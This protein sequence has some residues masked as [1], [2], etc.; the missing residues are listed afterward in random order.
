MRYRV[1]G[2]TVYA[3]QAAISASQPARWLV[4]WISCLPPK[5]RCLDY[6]C[7]RL[8]YATHL[9]ARAENTTVVDSSAQL[10]RVMTIHG[11][12]C[13]IPEFAKRHHRNMR[14]IA[15]R[16]FDERVFYDLAIC[17]NVLSSIPNLRRR[18]QVC[19]R[20]YEAL[21]PGGAALFVNQHRN[22]YFK[23]YANRESAKRHL[24]GWLIPHD[25]G[26]WF[27]GLIPPAALCDMVSKSGLSVQ[28]SGCCGESGFAL[29][30]RGQAN[31]WLHLMPDPRRVRQQGAKEN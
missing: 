13:T 27:Y 15:A 1:D 17:V 29:C 23:Q 21:V 16:A 26:Y 19:R 14:V 7:G 12:I 22:S 18:R 11:E 9:A 20:I 31:K 3:E 25:H 2:R 6:G 4:S 28:L 24:D 10:A 30:T 8:R 5:L